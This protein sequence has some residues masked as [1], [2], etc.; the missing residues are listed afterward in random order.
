LGQKV[1]PI[2]LRLGITRKSYSNWYSDDKVADYVKEDLTIRK[3][4]KE[5][6]KK[7]GI[8][9]VYI[10]RKAQKV[11]VELNASRP[12]I[13]IGKK[14]EEVEKVKSELKYIT[15][16]DVE[17]SVKEIKKPEVDAQLVA[18]NIATQIEGRVAYKRAVK[19]AISTAM[20][21][22]TEGIKIKV[23]GRLNGAE[24]ARQEEFK[25]GRTPLHTLRADID[26]ATATAHT[27]YGC[28]GIKVWICKGEKLSLKDE[29][30]S[31]EVK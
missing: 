22:D 13:I 29:R 1:N 10:A 6:L 25:E 3:Y 12:G 8:S 26:Y 18:D 20:R 9:S 30:A 21:M 19:K 15:K 7:A 27:T 5:R 4:L 31:E 11:L 14:G 2:G 16:K 23:G 28:I 24:I 17:V